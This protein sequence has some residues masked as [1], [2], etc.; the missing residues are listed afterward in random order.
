MVKKLPANRKFKA[1]VIG[2]SAG[3]IQILEK[4]L[5]HVPS[6]CSIPI[7]I[8]MHIGK[9][10]LHGIIQHLNSISNI[11]VK[12][13][14]SDTLVEP[15]AIYF[16]PPDYHLQI[17]PD[18]TFSLSMEEEINYSR[19]SIDVLFETAAHAYGKNLIGL[20]LTGA[21][22]DGTD[23]MSTNSPMGEVFL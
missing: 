2:V 11:P 10:S 9:H 16:A 23:G 8:A 5:P 12:E 21:N 14:Q 19:P 18:L 4:I 7:I 20:I 1:L 17:E 22:K 15:C 3:A 6:D 13:A